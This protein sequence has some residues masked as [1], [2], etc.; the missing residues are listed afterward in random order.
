[1]RTA[2][3]P[4]GPSNRWT[5]PPLSTNTVLAPNPAR[6]LTFFPALWFGWLRRVTGSIVPAILA[7]AA[8]NLLQTACLQ[9]FGSAI[10]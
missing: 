6:L 10:G 7:H 5:H 9:A 1:M 2:A 3:D 8:S 4:S